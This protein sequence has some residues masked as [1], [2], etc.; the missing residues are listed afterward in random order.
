MADYCNCSRCG[1][2][3]HSQIVREW[4][5]SNALHGRGPLLCSY[6]QTFSQSTTPSPP[7]G[8]M[9]RT[10]KGAPRWRGR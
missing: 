8:L 2:K 9:D 6:C 1:D 3:V 5:D 10:P 4:I 7:R